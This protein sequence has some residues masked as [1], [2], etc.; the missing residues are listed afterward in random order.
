MKKGISTILTV[1]LTAVVALALAA[2]GYYY[3]N[4]QNQDDTAAL[5]AQITAL[6][7]DLAAAKKAG[8]TA[9]TSTIS[10]T[11]TATS[12]AGWKTYTN[13]TYG[14][15]FK[16]PNDFYTFSNDS[17]YEQMCQAEAKLES[18]LNEFSTS[19]TCIYQGEIAFISNI[20]GYCSKGGCVGTDL[21]QITNS[22]LHKFIF[23]EKISADE[24][25]SRIA[26]AGSQSGVINSKIGIVD[27]YILPQSGDHHQAYG[28]FNVTGNNFEIITASETGAENEEVA[29]FNQIIPTVAETK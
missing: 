22:P 4:K 18:S 12:T 9:A 3:I 1:C 21:K 19:N 29:L 11:T 7:T 8:T 28:F 25:S 20:N 15:S 10:D 16:Y 13:S 26:Q 27:K 2:G 24:K 6:T 23:I 5:R 17:Q 14:F